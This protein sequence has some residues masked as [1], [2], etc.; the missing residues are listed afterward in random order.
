[1]PK[2]LLLSFD[3]EPFPA[4]HFGHGMT[5]KKAAQ[6]S[7]KGLSSL[8]KM[9]QRNDVKATFFVTSNFSKHCKKE[10]K[11]LLSKGNEIACHG[12]KHEDDY[13]SMPSAKAS[14]RLSSARLSLEKAFKSKILGFRAPRM[15]LLS[16]ETVSKAGFSYDSSLHPTFLP[17]YYNNFLKPRHPFRNGKI[18]VMPASVAPI[19]RA[20]FTFVFFKNLGLGYAKLC[21]ELCLLDSNFLHIYFHP[22]DF[23]NVNQSKFPKI[24]WYMLRNNGKAT[25]KALEAYIKWCKKKGLKTKTISQYLNE[26]DLI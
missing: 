1:M 7:K 11:Q 5:E 25:L 3:L 21:S 16:P 23:A 15:Q 18:A 24:P 22:W 17:G 8:L 10:L 13:L 9:L 4:E 26:R 2:N 20:P 14:K 19:V 12:F 6:L